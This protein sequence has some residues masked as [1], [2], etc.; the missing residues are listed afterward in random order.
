MA[1]EGADISYWTLVTIIGPILLL[2]AM[3]WAFFRN[4]KSK[5][6][7]GITEEGTKRVYEEEERAHRR[8]PGSGL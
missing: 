3:L 2:G 6:D 1:A 8:D 7:P 5:I 4:K